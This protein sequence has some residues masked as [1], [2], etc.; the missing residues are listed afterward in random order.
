LSVK[1]SVLQDLP[2]K[3]FGDTG[4]SL[5]EAL[6]LGSTNSQYDKRLFNDL[7]VQYMKTTSSEHV[8]CKFFLQANIFESPVLFCKPTG[9]CTQVIEE[10]SEFI[11]R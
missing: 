8:V 11:N 5:S 10:K 1:N 6:I 9:N 3:Q 7:P 2:L 4:K